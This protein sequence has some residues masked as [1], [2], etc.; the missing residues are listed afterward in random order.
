[1]DADTYWVITDDDDNEDDRWTL[2]EKLS[3]VALVQQFR[4][5]PYI[6]PILCYLYLNKY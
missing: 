3:L 2:D 1:M 4:N 6:L 5:I